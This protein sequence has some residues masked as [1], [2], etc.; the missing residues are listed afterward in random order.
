MIKKFIVELMFK[1]YK[2]RVWGK[3]KFESLQVGKWSFVKSWYGKTVYDIAT[4]RKT[5]ATKKAWQD[6][7]N[8]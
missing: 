5:K 2:D 3:C 4:P 6:Y 8:K 1:L 7:S